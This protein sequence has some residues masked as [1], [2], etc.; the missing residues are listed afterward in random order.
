MWDFPLLILLAVDAFLG[1]SFCLLM[2]EQVCL[3][4]WHS[5]V[6]ELFTSGQRVGHPCTNSKPLWNI[7][8]MSSLYSLRVV[9]CAVYKFCLDFVYCQM[10]YFPPTVDRIEPEVTTTK[11]LYSDQI[12]KLR[13]LMIAR[14]AKP[15]EV[16]IVEDEN[17]NIVRET[18][19]DSDVL[20]QYRVPTLYS[21]YLLLYNILSIYQ[22][23]TK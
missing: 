14:M 6:S 10:V 8:N 11:I 1:L 9:Y 18:M 12:S 21:Y 16:L 22:I 7:A 20:F 15:E 13:G 19:K 3:D 5:L 4:C 17:G 23:Y 2:S